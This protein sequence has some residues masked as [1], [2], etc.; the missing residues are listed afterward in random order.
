MWQHE[1]AL[2][3]SLQAEYRIDLTDFYRG[4]LSFRR[5]ASLVRHL[6]DT[7]ALSREL[8]DGWT[9][10]DYLIG[11]VYYSLTEEY[12]PGDPRASIPKSQGQVVS[13]KEAKERSDARRKRLGITG[14]VLRRQ[15]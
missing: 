15:V 7:S 13:I 6:S 12:A 4:W 1:S 9:V 5:L 10:T 11:S 14:S 3:A 2:E 8:G